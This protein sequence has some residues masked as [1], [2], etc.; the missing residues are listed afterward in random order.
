MICTHSV[1]SAPATRVEDG[2]VERMG[3][4]TPKVRVHGCMLRVQYVWP[5]LAFGSPWVYNM[6]YSPHNGGMEA[7]LRLV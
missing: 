3:G 4:F 7:S 6:L 1:G 2:E 5:W